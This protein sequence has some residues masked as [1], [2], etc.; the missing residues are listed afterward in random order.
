M[1][2]AVQ[3]AGLSG[4]EPQWAGVDL[5]KRIIRVEKWSAHRSSSPLGARDEA[6]SGVVAVRVME[7]LRP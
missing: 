6:L 4:L 1:A 2:A 5:K 3:L 7:S